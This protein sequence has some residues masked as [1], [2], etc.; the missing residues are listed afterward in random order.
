MALARR[1]DAGVVMGG[2][3]RTLGEPSEHRAPVVV[4]DEASIRLGF[5][6]G[7]AAGR[8]AAEF[9]RDEL[10][11]TL[12]VAEEARLAEALAALDLQREAYRQGCVRLAMEVND[13][14]LW[15]EGLAV[16]VAYAA[17]ARWSGEHAGD[18]GW[19]TRCCT[20]IMKDMPR[21]R[22][23]VRVAA[24]DAQALGTAASGLDIC[25]DSS[26][27]PGEFVIETPRGDLDMGI[28][29]RMDL[30]RDALLGTLTQGG[31][32]A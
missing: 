18:I 5:E 13:D 16:E 2:S 11:S 32:A 25:A 24:V 8:Q 10:L 29:T 7:L 4:P 23:V 17:M 30:L 3:S 21:V 1:V 26:L 12:R 19:L 9:E 31:S 6:E 27:N 15:A 28:A 22:F 20:E 14:R